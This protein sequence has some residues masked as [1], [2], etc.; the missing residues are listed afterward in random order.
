[1]SPFYS[2]DQGSPGLTAGEWPS[3]AYSLLVALEAVPFQHAHDFF[4]PGLRRCSPKFSSLCFFV[5]LRE[6]QWPGSIP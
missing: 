5:Y 3:D 2:C 1:M 4:L 6:L